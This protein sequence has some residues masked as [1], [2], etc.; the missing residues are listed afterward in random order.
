MT[1]TNRAENND[2]KA[3]A[4]AALDAKTM[5]LTQK[6]EKVIGP[7]LVCTSES[8]EN[9][10]YLL[11]KSKLVI[12][13]SVEADLSL[14]DPLVSRKHCVIEKQDNE[15]VARNVSTT[16]PLRLNDKPIIEKRLFTGDVLKIGS[17]TLAF[18]SDRPE[19]ARKQNS[20]SASPNWISQWGLW[21]AVCLL[22]V[23]TGYFGYFH[24]YRPLRIKWALSSASQQIEAE[25][26][27]TAQN[28]LKNLL[29]LDLSP[30]R[31]EQAMELL[32]NSTLA[33]AQ[34]KAQYEDLEAAMD[35]LNTYLAEYGGGKEAEVLWDR[36]DYYRLSLAHSLESAK[37]LQ[38]ALT[39]YAAIKDDSIYFE[40]AH[41]AIRRIWLAHQQ[42]P[43]RDQ[44]LVQLLKDADKHFRAR[45]Y[46]TPVNENA[47]VLYQAVLTLEPEHKLALSRID[48][49]KT[50]YS[51]NGEKHF[52][53]KNW[54]RALSYFERYYLIDADNKQINEKLKVCREKLA[55]NGTADRKTRQAKNSSKKESRGKHG[56]NQDGGQAENR[57]EIKRLLQESGTQSTWIM[58]YLFED[59]QGEDGSEKPW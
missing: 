54:S 15:F 14:L 22:V 48:Q 12:G 59:R 6:K 21:I 30:E 9:E 8:G 50:F 11:N 23:F 44:T 26:H 4:G 35:Y 51:Q 56:T 5:V 29:V 34:Q 13:R 43:A 49:M 28:T 53:G 19:D 39:H 24:G 20:A 31:T 25:K 1:V 27:Q 46:L 10:I 33:V 55:R 17:A 52:A 2:N 38:A 40:E 18:I 36:L 45:Q 7:R 32:A 47:F 3:T 57:E 58:K 16:N 37:K 41:K 42:Q